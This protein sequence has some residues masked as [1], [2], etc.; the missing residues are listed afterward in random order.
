MKISNS[1]GIGIRMICNT[2]QKNVEENEE[3]KMKS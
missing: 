1:V 3:N 2:L